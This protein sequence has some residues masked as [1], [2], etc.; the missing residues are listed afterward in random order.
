MPATFRRT[1]RLTSRRLRALE[2]AA[3][4]V[5]L[6][7][8]I[9]W[10]G[11]TM[12][13]W[14]IPQLLLF[15][16][17]CL[18]LLWRDASFDRRG[19]MAWPRPW[20]PCLLRIAAL[21]ILGGAAV[22]ALAIQLP[23]TTPFALPHERPGLWLAILLLYPLL[24]AL[25]QELIF[26]VFVFHRYRALFPG[27]RT[28]PLVSA[29]VFALAHLVL[30]NWVALWL[31]LAGGLLFAYTYARTGSLGLVTLEHGLWGGWL[32]TVGMGSHFYGGHV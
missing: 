7:L 11:E 15:T 3:L 24:S 2:F 32:F 10:Q 19:L 13:R 17:L 5:L 18:I 14:I 16:T 22:L 28:L 6:P 27:P 20:R 21:L 29:G 26:R 4:F 1:F 30:G 25:P 9:A 31:S 12:R 23:D 8:V